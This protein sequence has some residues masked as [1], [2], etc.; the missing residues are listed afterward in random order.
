MRRSEPPKI[1]KTVPPPART[2]RD[3][4]SGE[5]PALRTS[6]V[7]PLAPPPRRL[8]DGVETVTDLRRD[9]FESEVRMAKAR[10]KAPPDPLQDTAP[11]QLPK[12]I[13]KS[14]ATDDDDLASDTQRGEALA[15]GADAAHADPFIVGQYDLSDSAELTTAQYRAHALQTVGEL[16][17]AET[18]VPDPSPATRHN[19]EMPTVTQARE[20]LGLPPVT[21][22]A[23]PSFPQP[24][25]TS[26]SAVMLG[27]DEIEEL[28]D[29]AF[30]DGDETR[31]GERPKPSVPSY[32]D[33]GPATL[34]RQ[35][36]GFEDVQ[37]GVSRGVETRRRI[38][39]PTMPDERE[40]AS[41]SPPSE[42]TIA[43]PA[44]ES[45]SRGTS[46]ISEG[47]DRTIAREAP[48]PAPLMPS[49]MRPPENG[50]RQARIEEEA[51][52]ASAAA[53]HEADEVD[54]RRKLVPPTM[55]SAA[56]PAVEVQREAIVDPR[57]DQDTGE[58][59][60]AQATAPQVVIDRGQKVSGYVPTQASAAVP[61]QMPQMPQMP[62]VPHVPHVP[63]GNG[64]AVVAPTPYMHHTP[65]GPSLPT[66]GSTA[67]GPAIVASTPAAL[68][69][70]PMQHMQ[71]PMMMAQPMPM[72]HMQQP[73]PMPMQHMQQPMPMPM[74][75]MQ[76]PM[77]MQHMQQ[78]MHMQHM[79]QPMMMAQPMPIQH[80][81]QPMPMQQP[82]MG[83]PHGAPMDP[84]LTTVPP[85]SGPQAYVTT[86]APVE[87][88][89]RYLLWVAYGIVVGGLALIAIARFV[90]P[91][92]SDEPRTGTPAATGSASVGVGASVT[93][94]PPPISPAAV[95]PVLGQ[96]SSPASN[97]NGSAAAPPTS[98]QPTA[99]S[100]GAT[101]SAVRPHSGGGRGP[102]PAPRSGPPAPSAQQGPVSIDP[103]SAPPTPQPQSAD[104]IL[105]NAL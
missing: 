59:P 69:G 98:A 51:R 100:S 5:K 3:L 102:A 16:D 18:H 4:E 35:A 52:G 81:Q 1:R 11:T 84:R 46:P 86:Q 31:V 24:S 50:L 77:P 63:Q 80:M 10:A 74:Q 96:A 26:A 27:T 12:L 78:P 41:G 21:K 62:Q 65:V 6:H 22:V 44:P 37:T 58:R 25:S 56:R 79:Q 71:Q 95:P 57:V 68:P 67:P 66:F 93:P 89:R 30:G 39:L 40:L 97:A 61:M 33:D 38:E 75:P 101:P 64:G 28:G 53:R 60:I 15:E 103:P 55:A 72:Q 48:A 83:M 92:S 17:T 54:A 94:P 29:A 73:M 9:H 23:P 42:A 105:D 49:R 2:T 76:Q 47:S 88:P 19:I 20:L 70:V 8:H 82:M 14:R 32:A 91:P 104:S 34:F 13:A 90:V 7:P 36:D 99:T 43:R 45:A 87:A 85:S